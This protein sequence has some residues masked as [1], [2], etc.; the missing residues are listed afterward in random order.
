MGAKY[1]DILPAN[2]NW[3]MIR[4]SL[5][6]R[7]RR[8]SRIYTSRDLEEARGIAESSEPLESSCGSD[9]LDEDGNLCWP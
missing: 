9:G 1:D 4:S 3:S 6:D 2:Q 8:G 5:K 7:A